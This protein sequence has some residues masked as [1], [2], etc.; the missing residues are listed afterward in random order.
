MPPTDNILKEFRKRHLHELAVEKDQ[1]KKY[2]AKSPRDAK[3]FQ[4]ET[5]TVA[6]MII[7][8]I[9]NKTTGDKFIQKIYRTQK[10]SFNVTI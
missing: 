3:H 7:Q 1:L 2:R 5:A 8:K 6:K 4:Q 9:A 10:V